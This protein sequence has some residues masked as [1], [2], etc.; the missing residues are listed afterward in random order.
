MNSKLEAI[1]VHFCMIALYTLSLGV[2]L[3]VMKELG[4][5]FFRMAAT[6][7]WTACIVL[8][9]AALFHDLEKLRG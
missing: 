9:F 1:F 3:Y 5:T 4:I 7:G 8:R 6:L 2:V